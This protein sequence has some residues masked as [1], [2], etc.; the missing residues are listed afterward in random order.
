MS[1]DDTA[2]VRHETEHRVCDRRERRGHALRNAAYRERLRGNACGLEDPG[3]RLVRED[4]PPVHEDEVDVS[5]RGLE[6]RRTEG[7]DIRPRARL[8]RRWGKGE[9]PPRRGP[10]RFLEPEVRQKP[11]CARGL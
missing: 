9:S 8:E 3:M 11:E 1:R 7:D 2:K 10:D 6:E 5:R 4:R